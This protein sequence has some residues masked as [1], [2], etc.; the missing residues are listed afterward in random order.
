MTRRGGEEVSERR[1][2]IGEDER[3]PVMAR[4]AAQWWRSNLVY[5]VAL[6]KGNHPGE[7]YVRRGRRKDLCR[8][9][10]DS[11]EGPHEEAK[12]QRNGLQRRYMLRKEKTAVEGDPKKSWSRD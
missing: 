12:I 3:Q 6:R 9:E 10:R 1:R 5:L 7:A 11:L 8:T 4:L 2:G